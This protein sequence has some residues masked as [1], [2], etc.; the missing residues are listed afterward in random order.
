MNT[1]AARNQK[2]MTR[3]AVVSVRRALTAPFTK[4]AWAQLGYTLV[5]FPLAIVAFAFMV[6]MLENGLFW[7]LSA[8]GMRKFADRSRVLAWKLLGER[9][10]P[11]LPLRP[12]PLVVVHT[13]DAG[14]LSVAIGEAGGK[15]RQWA[16]NYGSGITVC[17]FPSSRI[18][19]LAA[20]QSITIRD[21]RP[22]WRCWDWYRG[23]VADKPAWRARVYFAAKLPLAVAGLIVAAGCW[24]GGLFC[25]TCPTW[26][27]LAR[28]DLLAT[29]HVTSIATS[30]PPVPL[31]AALLLAGPW[32]LHGITDADRW[33]IC[34]LLGPGSPA[35][36]T[37]A[38]EETPA[39]AVDD[40]A[41]RLRTIERA[42]S[43]TDR[44]ECSQQVRR[45]DLWWSAP[46]AGQADRATL[47]AELFKGAVSHEQ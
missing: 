1:L 35:E 36:Q 31:G 4:R 19:E 12:R 8:P 3:T 5:T 20:G 11:P 16:F 21:M 2:K 39:I 34:G 43:G 9:V 40:A 42:S 37:R 29:F 33:L 17:N 13:P 46:T 24:C 45:H 41:A 22:G 7:A 14:R 38:L 6:P 25:L 23:A 27:W 30:F 26:W 47:M 10:L 15:V 28:G 18:A 44:V 32:L